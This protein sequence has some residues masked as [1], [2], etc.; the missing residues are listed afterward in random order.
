MVLKTLSLIT[1]FIFSLSAAALD[2]QAYNKAVELVQ[3]NR[4]ESALRELETNY[5]LRSRDLP[6]K[7]AT[8]A[9]SLLISLKRWRKAEQ[10]ADGA[11]MVNWPG[12]PTN[13]K[14]KNQAELLSLVKMSAEAKTEIYESGDES[15]DRHKLQ[16]EIKTYTDILGGD[17]TKAEEGQKLLARV[18]THAEIK[19]A[20]DFHYDWSLLL[21][22]WTWEDR[23]SFDFQLAAKSKIFS[24][25]FGL[26]VDYTNDF[27]HWA[28][29]ACA[30]AGSASLEFNDGHYDNRAKV[31][32]LA[33]YGSILLKL[34]NAGSA[35]GLEGDV[36]NIATSGKLA[37]GTTHSSSNEEFAITAVGRYRAG[38]FDLK[39]KGGPVISTLSAL[40]SFELAYIF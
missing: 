24:P 32:L 36:M 5:N 13:K 4:K 9:T 26:G 15:R 3:K 11:L 39:F 20:S 1:V 25:C 19:K 2:P 17:N 23:P 21:S 8:L 16:E 38:K 12:W 28:G 6:L 35:F 37:D 27:Y 30:G 33:G 7:V 18:E 10:V 22:Y 40:W 34:S 29:G 14:I 31:T